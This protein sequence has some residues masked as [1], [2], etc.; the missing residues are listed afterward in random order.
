MIVTG[1]SI[2]ELK[3]RTYLRSIPVVFSIEQFKNTVNYSPSRITSEVDKILGKQKRILGTNLRRLYVKIHYRNF[4]E[5][6]SKNPF[7]GA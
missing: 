2:I 6:R 4:K 5:K 3:Y 1:A 7:P